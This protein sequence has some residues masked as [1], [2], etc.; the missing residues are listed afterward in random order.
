MLLNLIKGDIKLVGVRPIS[1]HY[2]SLYKQDLVELRKKTKPGLLP[3]YYADMPKT[4]DEIMN[5]E[6]HYLKQ[7]FKQ[8]I[9]TDILY[10]WKI[11]YNIFFGKARSS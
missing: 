10:L 6:E 9:K 3:P 7:Y 2:L 4:F 5:S 1:L 8:P 11:C